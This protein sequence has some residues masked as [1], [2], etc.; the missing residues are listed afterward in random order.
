M[1]RKPNLFHSARKTIK[2]CG[3]FPCMYACV[4]VCEREENLTSSGLLM[5]ANRENLLGHS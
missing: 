4:Y 1:W 2:D 3:F 5:S